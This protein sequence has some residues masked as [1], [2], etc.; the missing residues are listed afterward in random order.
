MVERHNQEAAAAT[1]RVENALV[2]LGSDHIDHHA[3][4]VTRSE[5][6][7]LLLFQRVRG[8][9]L[10]GHPF[11]VGIGRKQVIPRKLGRDVGQRTFVHFQ[12]FEA[13]K[14]VAELVLHAIEYILYALGDA[15]LPFGRV[16]LGRADKKLALTLLLIEDLG[17][18]QVKKLPE[19]LFVAKPLRGQVVVAVLEC[20]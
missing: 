3:D 7:S 15:R 19:C 4:D 20:A 5:E 1:R 10:E 17:E 18:N 14:H 6:L 16:S 13:V 2:G 8:D 11:G 12:A 9:G